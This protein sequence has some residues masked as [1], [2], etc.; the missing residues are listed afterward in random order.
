MAALRHRYPSR[1][2]ER[3]QRLSTRERALVLL[4]VLAATWFAW[5]GTVG[6][7][8][9]QSSAQLSEA[10][11]ALDARVQSEKAERSRL[12]AAR[13][14][15]PN[16]R[17]I[18]QREQLDRQLAALNVSLG[19]LLDRFVDPGDMPDL[20]EDVIRRHGGLT[21]IEMESL[22][23]E[24][25]E[26]AAGRADTAVPGPV[27]VYRHP[28]RLELEGGY[29]DVVAYLA[30][31]EDSDWAFGWRQLNY[32]VGDYPVATVTLEIETLSR[33]QSW[34]GV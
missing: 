12:E 9:G 15:D 16:A 29:F 23:A 17:L 7:R 13:D 1:L 25:V 26:L 30:E 27:R 10:V 34:I 2:A 31:L 24:P 22:P 28:I 32:E 21:L 19:S 14:S 3:Y 18:Q 6:S 20:L 11:G 33:E 4:T 5:A 8:L